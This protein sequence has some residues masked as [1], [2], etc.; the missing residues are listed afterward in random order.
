M[1]KNLPLPVF[2]F[3]GSLEE[4]LIEERRLTYTP[5]VR[6]LR[7]L[8]TE[9]YLEKIKTYY[10]KRKIIATTGIY[11]FLVEPLKN[12]NFHGLTKSNQIIFRIYMTPGALVASYND[13]GPYFTRRD[14]KEA[15]ELNKEDPEKHLTIN[16]EIGFGV[17][18]TVR[19]HL[20]QLVYVE[21]KTGTL[22]TGISIET[23]I[24]FDKK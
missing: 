16:P 17:G 24:L 23:S 22:F 15:Y 13:G 19:E 1:P 5:E 11:N 10:A 20:A 7:K 4:L 8:T 12:A 9:L 6:D 21:N 18:K 2:N 14:V 3:L